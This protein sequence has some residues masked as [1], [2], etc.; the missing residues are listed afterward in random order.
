MIQLGKLALSAAIGISIFSGSALAQ[1]K[2]EDAVKYRQAV[3][4]VVKN[5][6][7]PIAGVAKG[8]IPFKAEIVAAKATNLVAISKMS[9]EGYDNKATAEVKTSK[10]KPEVWSKWADFEAGMKK[11]MAE[12]EKLEV[13]AKS[14]NL[15]AIKAQTGE[16]GKTCKGCH[17]NFKAE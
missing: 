14:G 6:F 8:E 5:N 9:L 17:D 13:A 11:F 2:P 15:D 3:M 4:T 16:V 10:A 12:A 1:A 7:G